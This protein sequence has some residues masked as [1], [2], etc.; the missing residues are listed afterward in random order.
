MSCGDRSSRPQLVIQV[1]ISTTI[2]C[3]SQLD[4]QYL[5][6]QYHHH[7]QS[8][9]GS[10]FNGVSFS[11]IK[12]TLTTHCLM[13]FDRVKN[14]SSISNQIQ[15]QTQCSPSHTP[16]QTQAQLEQVPLQ[17]YTTCTRHLCR[18]I[19]FCTSLIR[20]IYHK[21]VPYFSGI[22]HHA[23]F[24]NSNYFKSHTHTN[25]LNK[26]HIFWSILEYLIS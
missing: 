7:K 9:T 3:I 23:L 1:Q 20:T 15:R 21:K 8:I 6:P 10:E 19:T 5:C 16:Q 25:I 2:P 12:N 14:K 24:Q 4:G 26:R 11:C 17:V 18:G 22:Y 13:H